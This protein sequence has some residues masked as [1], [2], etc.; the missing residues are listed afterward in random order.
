MSADLPEPAI[1]FR[2]PFRYANQLPEP[3]EAAIVSAKRE[4]PHWGAREI[5]DRLL[6]RMPHSIKTPAASSIHAVL[7]RHRLLKRM[8]RRRSRAEGTP[9]SGSNLCRGQQQPF[10]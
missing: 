2:R 10:N 1:T 5:R 8:G 4:K 3:L 9:L 7:D 6:R